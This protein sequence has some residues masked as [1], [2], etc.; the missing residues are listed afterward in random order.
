[1]NVNEK[2]AL[3]VRTGMS[4]RVVLDAM[5]ETPVAAEVV[6]VSP[7]VDPTTRTVEAEVQLSNSDG[8]LRPG[9]YG[10]GFIQLAMHPGAMVVPVTAV[11]I[12]SRGRS[13]FV[14]EGDHTR[15]RPIILGVEVDGG[16]SFEVVS[17]LKP[18]DQVIIAGA[19]GLSDGAKVRVRQPPPRAAAP[20]STAASSA[21]PASSTS[22]ASSA[23]VTNVAP[24]PS[25]AAR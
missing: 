25:T 7:A 8:R 11:Q 13:V 19:D 21:S 9:M 20:D 2:D 1:V 16:S 4:A 10:R 3:A 14:I 6:R 5:P 15:V 12:N 22:P 18:G 17:G 23:P 24:G